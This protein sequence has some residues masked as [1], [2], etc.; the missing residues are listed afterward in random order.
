MTADQPVYAIA[1]KVQWSYPE[2]YGEDC[3]LLMMMGAL[4]I[5]MATLNVLGDWLEGRGWVEVL[6]KA[7]TNSPGR[8]ESVLSGTH[9]KRSRYVH[10]VTCAALHLH[11]VSAYRKSSTDL[12]RKSSTDLSNGLQQGDPLQHTSI[13]G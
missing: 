1:K 12:Y 13:I 6:I 10:Q 7:Q 8:A 3:K 4:H 5:E 11:L 2:L 9:V